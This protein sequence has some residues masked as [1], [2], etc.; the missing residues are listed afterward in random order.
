M[1]HLVYP[2][3]ALMTPFPV[4][5]TPF[6][7]IPFANNEATGCINEAT[8]GANKGATNP[9]YRFFISCCI[10]SVTPSFSTLEFS[11]DLLMIIIPFI[12]SFK[13]N[14]VNPF[15]ALTALSLSCGSIFTIFPSKLSISNEVALV[16]NS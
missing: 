12:S 1:T 15:P 8:I 2:L 16:T 10:V 13:M 5:M 11:N 7:K 4:L 9:S 14:K 3:P 6:S